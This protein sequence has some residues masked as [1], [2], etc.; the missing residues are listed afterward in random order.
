[1]KNVMPAGAKI[2]FFLPPV[3]EDGKGD[4]TALLIGIEPWMVPTDAKNPN[5]AVA[6]FKYMT[7][8]ANAKKFVEQ[9]GTLMSIKGSDQVKFPETL[10]APV[11]AYRQSKTVWANRFAEWYPAFKDEVGNALTAMLN[12]QATPEQ[13]CDRVEAAAEKTRKDPNIK[14]HKL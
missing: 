2:R 8:L 11:A 3:V 7:S 10:E 13:F 5:A 12:G 6:L 14:K 1:M 9:K 4:P